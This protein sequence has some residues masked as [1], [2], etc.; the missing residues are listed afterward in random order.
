METNNKIERILS[1]YTRLMNGE[2]VNKASEAQRFGVNGRSIQRDIDDIRNFLDQ[3]ATEEGNLNSVLYDR[4][5]HGYRLEQ[6]YRMK[7]TNA[8][9]LAICKI[10]LDSRAFSPTPVPTPMAMIRI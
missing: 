7:F 2:V 6:I 4:E 9:I 5:R 3:S 10:L 1:I 8:E